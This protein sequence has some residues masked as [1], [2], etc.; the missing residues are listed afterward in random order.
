MTKIQSEKSNRL[1]NPGRLLLLIGALVLLFIYGCQTVNKPPY[2]KAFQPEQ[3]AQNASIV[4][5]LSKETIPPSNGL[6]FAVLGDWGTGGSGQAHV[7]Q[8]LGRYIKTQQLEF[9]V[10]TGDNFYPTGLAS[11]DDP[12]FKTHFIDMI[13]SGHIDIPFHISVGNHDHYGDVNAQLAVKHPLW[14]LPALYYDFEKKIDDNYIARFFVLDTETLNKGNDEQLAWLQ[15]ACHE[16]PAR[17]K[18]AVAHHPTHTGGLHR[19]DR[20]TRDLRKQLIPLFK[21]CGI[22]LYLAGHDHHME[23]AE[24]DSDLVEVISGAGGG[25]DKARPVNPAAWTRYAST[26]GGFAEIILGADSAHIGMVDTK[27]GQTSTQYFKVRHPSLRQ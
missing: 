1:H 22:H 18:I 3:Q 2:V 13:D 19:L 7:F 4:E 9:V 26:G 27:P 10:T 15:S 25:L 8:E 23:L 6:R 5:I 12:I 24:I 21:S 20:E 16:R 17:W 14:Q 11:S